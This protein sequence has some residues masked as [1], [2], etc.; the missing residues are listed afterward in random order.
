MAARTVPAGRGV[1]EVGRANALGFKDH[2][3][4]WAWSV[5]CVN[6]APGLR[7]A[8]LDEMKRVLKP[9]EIHAPLSGERTAALAD[10]MAMRWGTSPGELDEEELA[11]YH[12]LTDPASENCIYHDPDYY[13][14]FTY[15]LFTGKKRDGGL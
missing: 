4:D 6:Y 13:G 2:W 3:F 12:S 8:A 5:D 11:L 10:L 1:F 7:R 15:T 14:F 9:G